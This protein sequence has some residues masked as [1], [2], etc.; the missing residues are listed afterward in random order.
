M[1][2]TGLFESSCTYMRLISLV[3]GFILFLASL[4]VMIRPLSKSRIYADEEKRTRAVS[5][6]IK[7]QQDQKVHLFWMLV[8]CAVFVWYIGILL[9]SSYMANLTVEKK[10]G[11]A[12]T[13]DETAYSDYNT[14]MLIPPILFGIGILSNIFATAIRKDDSRLFSAISYLSILLGV[15]AVVMLFRYVSICSIAAKCV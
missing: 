7:S 6:Y 8:I 13:E 1:M 3:M 5:L 15:I 11:C 12:G 14:Q 2:P 9:P 4:F 10:G